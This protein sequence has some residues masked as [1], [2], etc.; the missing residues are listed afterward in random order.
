MTDNCLIHPV[1][2]CTAD[3]LWDLEK[4][5]PIQGTS[6]ERQ[7]YTLGRFP[8]CPRDEQPFTLTLTPMGSGSEGLLNVLEES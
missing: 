1:I 4:L 8:I 2:I 6:G 3:L 5:E 7:G